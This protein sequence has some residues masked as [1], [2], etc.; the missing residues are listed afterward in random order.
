MIR[1]FET[2]EVKLNSLSMEINQSSEAWIFGFEL[3]LTEENTEMPHR[4][5]FDR[6][7]FL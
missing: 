4:S 1:V 3:Q 2:L 6:E 7:Q 5:I